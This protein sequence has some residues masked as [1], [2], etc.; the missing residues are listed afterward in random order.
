LDAALFDLHPLIIQGTLVIEFDPY[1]WI[2]PQVNVF[3]L[4]KANEVGY[5]S[6]F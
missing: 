2:V 3:Q 6:E 1:E 4:C 5:P